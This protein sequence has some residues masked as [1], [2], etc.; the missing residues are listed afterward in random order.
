MRRR[1]RQGFEPPPY[2]ASLFASINDGARAAQTGGLT[3]LAVAVYLMATVI[4]TTDE[5]RAG[6]KTG[7]IA[8]LTS[9]FSEMA[10]HLWKY[11]PLD[12]AACPSVGCSCRYTRLDQQVFLAEKPE[13]E[14]LYKLRTGEGDSCEVRVEEISQ[15]CVRILDS[16]SCK[17]HRADR[18]SVLT[19]QHDWPHTRWRDRGDPPPRHTTRPDLWT[20]SPTLCNDLGGS[21]IGPVTC[22]LR[23]R[24]QLG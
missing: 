23:A 9:V 4:S 7:K 10:A 16:R 20:A 13:G 8:A 17:R 2:I 21:T 18:S 22:Q 11:N 12:L 15:S 14:V 1:V 6:I 19:M 24:A 5:A 3:M